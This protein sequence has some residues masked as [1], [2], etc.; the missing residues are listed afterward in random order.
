MTAP[1]RAFMV[2]QAVLN[3][4]H[5]HFFGTCRLYGAAW[6]LRN[7]TN[8]GE[9]CGSIL[10]RYVREEFARISSHYQLNDNEEDREVEEAGNGRALR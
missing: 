7:V 9:G 8:D 1:S 6:V 10:T 2:Q 4:V 3:A 5:R